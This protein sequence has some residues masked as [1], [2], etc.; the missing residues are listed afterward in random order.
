MQS[1]LPGE[2]PGARAGVAPSRHPRGPG[3]VQPGARGYRPGRD[4]GAGSE[5]LLRVYTGWKA[6]PRS[7]TYVPLIVVKQGFDC[8]S[9]GRNLAGKS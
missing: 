5:L 9:S 7:S 1:A 8:R 6:D 2:V 4:R 3:L